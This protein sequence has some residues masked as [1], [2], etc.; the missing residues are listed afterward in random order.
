MNN[1]LFSHQPAE[2]AKNGAGGE[3]YKLSD[4]AALAQ[5]VVTGTFN[6]TMYVK[7]TD[8]LGETMALLKKVSPKFIAQLA[9]YAST[10]AYMKDTPV[11]LAVY[12]SVRDPG[13][14]QK[15]FPMVIRNGKDIRNFVKVVRSRTAGRSSMGSGPKNAVKHWIE[16]ASTWDLLNASVGNQPSLRDVMSLTH[17]RPN[18]PEKES[19]FK[20]LFGST[21]YN[22]Q[23]LPPEVQALRDFRQ[24]GYVVPAAPLMLLTSSIQN[25]RQWKELAKTLTWSQIR[26]NLN[27]LARHGVFQDKEITK[28]ILHRFSDMGSTRV[29]PYEILMTLTNL[30]PLV[31]KEFMNMLQDHL[32]TSFK[33][34]S[35]IDDVVVM[36]DNSQSM[37][38][39][40]I[41]SSYSSATCSQIAGLF[42]SA[43]VKKNPNASVIRFNTKAVDVVLNP[44]DSLW[45]NS[46]VLAHEYAGTDCSAPLR[47]LKSSERKFKN[48]IMISDNESWFHPNSTPHMA[49]NSYRQFVPGCKMVCID[50]QPKATT[51]FPGQ[52]ILRIG[53]FS[54]NVFKAVDSFFSGEYDS[55]VSKIKEIVV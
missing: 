2:A 51:P 19:L 33:N 7:A 42:A 43:I 44:R 14:F 39:K 6:D 26:M 48:L 53:G 4:E 11:F 20:F 35:A 55:F 45:T 27:S 49:W 50:I 16:N 5:L 41:A 46:K 12:L 37:G 18:T 40:A 38:A 52:N 34:V 24:G 1:K 32:E 17:P 22:I 31:P 3:V 23:H 8:L 47:L 21:D 36:V 54:D 25:E 9:V 29:F 10:Q 30:D 28:E 15:I 13:L